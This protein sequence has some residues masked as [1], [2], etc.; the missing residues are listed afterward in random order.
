MPQRGS[1]RLAIRRLSQQVW[2][3]FGDRI[4]EGEFAFLHQHQHRGS[5]NRFGHGCDPEDRIHAHERFVFGVGPT[6][7]VHPRHR[8]MR[9]DHRDRAGNF[10]GD[11]HV[12][13]ARRNGIEA[14]GS[15]GESERQQEKIPPKK[16]ARD[17]FACSRSP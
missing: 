17:E 16:M 14:D 2:N 15:L 11:D 5:R 13:H 1:L 6:L 4:V 12:V 10:V 9:R 8:V 3:V 7:S